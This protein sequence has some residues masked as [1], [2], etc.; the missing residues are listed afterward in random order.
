MIK[1]L[2]KVLFYSKIMLLVVVFTITLYIALSMN[3]YY[4]S[5]IINLIL[6]C[7]PFLL[8]LIMFI[9]SFFMSKWKDNLIYNMASNLAFI[10]I[11]IIDFRTI[12][13]KNMVMWIDGNMN[14]YYFQN[15]LL[16]ISI[17]AYGVF[18]G[19]ILLIKSKN[20]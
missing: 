3:A 10:A 8:I 2:N 14:F 17:L 5:N 18:I 11:L 19:S 16:Q 9:S 4:K 15:S 7:L 6:L 13:D 12:F 20:V 1:L